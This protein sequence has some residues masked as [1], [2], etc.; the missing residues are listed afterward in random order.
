MTVMALLV[1]VADKFDPGPGQCENL[2]LN[3]LHRFM[4]PWLD[5]A[6]AEGSQTISVPTPKVVILRSS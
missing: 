3:S 1:G 4:V 5:H 2:Y 6:E